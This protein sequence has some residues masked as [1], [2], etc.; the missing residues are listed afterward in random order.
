L[1]DERR[2]DDGRLR[3]DFW[4]DPPGLPAWARLPV[5]GER[6]QRQVR[7]NGEVVRAWP[8]SPLHELDDLGNL[9]AAVYPW[10]KEGAMW[11]AL[12]GEAPPA[13]PPIMVDLY[14]G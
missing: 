13:V 12:T 2:L 8:C 4:I 5:D 14:L 1:L 7:V 6:E 3:A 10:P 11:F 9:L